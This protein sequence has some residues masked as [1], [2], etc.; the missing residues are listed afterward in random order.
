M[1]RNGEKKFNL[2]MMIMQKSV[3]KNVFE[4]FSSFISSNKEKNSLK[5]CLD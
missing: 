1:E 3:K 4:V 2:T 5:D